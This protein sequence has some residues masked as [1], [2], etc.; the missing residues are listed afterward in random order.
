VKSIFGIGG[1]PAPRDSQISRPTNVQH[2]QHIGY[3][4][5]KGFEVSNIPPEWKAL[6]KSAGLKPKDLKDAATAAEIVKTMEQFAEEQGIDLPA[7]PFAPPVSASPAPASSPA[8][9]PPKSRAPPPPPRRGAPLPAAAKAGGAPPPPAAP[10][11][12]A[13]AAPPPPVAS[14]PPPPAA[15]GAPPRTFTCPCPLVF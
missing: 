14:A 2:L 1:A 10:S 8:S 9:G 7:A 6:F 5:D 12:P 3:D 4:P 13:P 15:G 11:A